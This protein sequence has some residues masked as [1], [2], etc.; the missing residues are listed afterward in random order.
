MVA[1]HRRKE[2]TREKREERREKLTVMNSRN[3]SLTG[4]DLLNKAPAGATM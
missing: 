4:D 3:R 1:G 2:K